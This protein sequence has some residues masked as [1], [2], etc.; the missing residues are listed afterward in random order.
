MK[1]LIIFGI[2]MLLL[3]YTAS[4]QE[5]NFILSSPDNEVIGDI[6]VNSADPDGN[7]NGGSLS[8]SNG[9]TDRMAYL[10]WNITGVVSTCTSITSA[11]MTLNFHNND[12]TVNMSAF[13]VNRTWDETTATFNNQPCDTQLN[14]ATSC[15]LSSDDTQKVLSGA[16][17]NIT[18]DVTAGMKT[19]LAEGRDNASWVLWSA[20]FGG[21]TIFRARDKEEQPNAQIL[22]VSCSTTDMTAPVVVLIAPTPEN[23][24][25]SSDNLPTFNMSIVEPNLDTITLNFNGTNQ[26]GFV[27]ELSNFW[28]LEVNTMAEGLFTYQIHV[29]DTLG[30]EFVSDELQ[31]SV[32]N[33][34]PQITFTF[35]SVLNNTIS[36]IN[37][38]VDILGFNINLNISNLTVFN[39]S[40]VQVFQNVTTDIDSST[41]SFV[42]SLAE[43]FA[44]EPSD[45]Y[46]F[47]AC[48]ID[49]AN[50]ETCQEVEMEL[51]IDSPVISTAINNNTP[52]VG[53][54]IQINGT[55]TDTNLQTL[56]LANNASGFVNITT[57][58]A[59]SP[60]TYLQNHTAVLGTI[61]HQFTC[62][63]LA[64]NSIQ[65]GFVL[66]TSTAAPLSTQDSFATTGTTGIITRVA[67]GAI[68][69]TVIIGALVTSIG[70]IRNGRRRRK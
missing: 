67:I 2:V 1:K 37:N 5:F 28:S 21:D 50:I 22:N 12:N 7:D 3:M 13:Y 59:V 49:S 62:N 11:D 25:I 70:G 55:C 31:F 35:P 53:D 16:P 4:A 42:N 15:N 14:D 56:F 65:S 57:E 61:S 66:Y 54:V 33:T 9:S 58:T 44:T 26:T 63:D 52:V 47:R 30:N 64:G 23:E 43:I 69:A 40:M 36:D 8:I 32:D 19:A 51:D 34:T 60:F 29:N 46:T 45:T 38:N 18:W 68:A 27:N 24:S 10:A 39:S 6:I 41:F 48:F 17:G 20:F